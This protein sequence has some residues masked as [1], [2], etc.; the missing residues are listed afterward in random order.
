MQVVDG[1][2]EKQYNISNSFHLNQHLILIEVQVK[3]K[4]WSGRISD[5]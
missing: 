1:Y 2:L 3:T 4:H 5:K